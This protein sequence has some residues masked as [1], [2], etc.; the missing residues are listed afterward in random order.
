MK[1]HFWKK[2][3]TK[4]TDHAIDIPQSMTQNKLFQP[5]Y[6]LVSAPI[7]HILGKIFQGNSKRDHI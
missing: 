4:R 2:T 7:S 1:Y 6:T 3:H 5:I